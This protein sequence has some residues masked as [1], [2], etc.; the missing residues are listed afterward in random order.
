M[1]KRRKELAFWVQSAPLMGS[2]ISVFSH[3]WFLQWTASPALSFCNPHGW[4]HP[5]VKTFLDTP[6]G[7]LTVQYCSEVLAP[8]NVSS[9]F[10]EL[11]SDSNCGISLLMA[12]SGTLEENFSNVLLAKHHC[13]ATLT[14]S[15]EPQPFTHQQSV[16][17]SARRSGC[18]LPLVLYL[19]LLGDHCSLYL[20]LLYSLELSLLVLVANTLLPQSRYS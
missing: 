17:F 3:F 5:A 10:G 16:N 7:G 4:E 2:S 20:P 13:T 14:T 11:Y 1:P 19:S 6:S 9:R 12:F 8:N 15:S 18:S